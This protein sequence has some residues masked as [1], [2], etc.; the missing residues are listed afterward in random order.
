MAV[1]FIRNKNDRRP[2]KNA[3]DKR[4]RVKSQRKRAI[5]LGVP[6]ELVEKMN[7][8]EVRTLILRPK[9]TAAQYAKSA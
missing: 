9:A 8:K 1:K 5:A 2:R 4:R 6:A 3:A 7:T